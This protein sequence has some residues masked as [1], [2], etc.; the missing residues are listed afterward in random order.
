MWALCDLALGTILARTTTFEMKDF[1]AE[2]RITAM[3]FKKPDDPNFVNTAIYL[4][5]ELQYQVFIQVPS[6]QF[7]LFLFLLKK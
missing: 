5:P 3:Y 2:P 1:P 7:Y 4:P 6:I